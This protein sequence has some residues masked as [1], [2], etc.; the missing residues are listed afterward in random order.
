[1]AGRDYDSFLASL[2]LHREQIEEAVSVVGRLA[3]GEKTGDDQLLWAKDL[4]DHETEG[5]EDHIS[6]GLM[7]RT[8]EQNRE[9][10]DQAIGAIERLVRGRHS[11]DFTLENG[12]SPA[13]DKLKR[14][15]LKKKKQSNKK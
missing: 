4:A 14:K 9:N 10:V 3:S 1:M 8:L 6:Y 12:K 11:D 13:K 15:N 5:D 7:L 2:R